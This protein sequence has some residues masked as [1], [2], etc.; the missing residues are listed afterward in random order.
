MRIEKLLHACDLL[1][2]ISKDIKVEMLINVMCV[3]KKNSHANIKLILLKSLGKGFVCDD[4]DIDTL[5]L[6][7]EKTTS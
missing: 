6:I 2:S 3:D 7:I 4:V 5:Q 1:S